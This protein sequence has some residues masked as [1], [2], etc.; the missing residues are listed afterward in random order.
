MIRFPRDPAL[1]LRIAGAFGRIVY[2]LH[3]RRLPLDKV[4]QRLGSDPPITGHQDARVDRI[5]RYTDLGRDLFRL[6]CLERT[7]VLYCLLRRSGLP[8]TFQLGARRVDGALDSHAWLTL[9]GH[10][11][12]ESPIHRDFTVLLTWPAARQ[13]R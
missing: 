11:V 10:P 2:W 3:V 1:A 12:F 9:D 6:K 5:V 8:V 13:S 4:L 7:L